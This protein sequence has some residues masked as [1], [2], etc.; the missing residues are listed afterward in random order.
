M[1]RLLLVERPK[2]PKAAWQRPDPKR[3]TAPWKREGGADGE[4]GTVSVSAGLA[5]M[6]VPFAARQPTTFGAVRQQA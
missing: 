3:S 4:S 2:V 1:L 5:S 6:R